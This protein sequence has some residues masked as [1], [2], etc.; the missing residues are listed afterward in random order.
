MLSTIR[1]GKTNSEIDDILRSK[2][3]SI[4][5]INAIDLSN[6]AII[7]S[8]RREQNHWNSIFLDKLD[9]EPFTFDATDS[10]VTGNPLSEAVRK[11]LHSYYKERLEDTLPLKV[12]ARV[13]LTKNIDVEN[14]WLNGTIA[15]VVSIQQ[16]YITIENVKTDKKTVVTWMKQNLSFPGSSVQNVHA[17]FPLFLGWA[18]TVHKVKGPLQP[19]NFF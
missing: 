15:N 3:V 8:F 17:Q 18:L 7:C 16:N 13:V 19:K 4:D 11:K 10:D 12:G 2:V 1:L 9:T 14:G 5:D 6:A